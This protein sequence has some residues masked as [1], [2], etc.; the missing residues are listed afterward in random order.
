MNILP[1]V[2]DQVYDVD[3]R[4][5][6]FAEIE[7]LGF[8]V[9]C[10]SCCAIQ[11]EDLVG[12][13]KDTYMGFASDARSKG[14]IA[15]VSI[16]TSLSAGDRVG[17]TEA[18]RDESDNPR[19][20]TRGFH[21]SYA[22]DSWKAYLIELIDL[23]VSV[24]GYQCVIL[25]GCTY[26]SDLPG[27]SGP[28]AAKFASE[29]PDIT[30]PSQ[31]TETSECLKAQQFRDKTVLG[32]F[33]DLA[34]HAKSIE[35][36]YVGIIPPFFIPTVGASGGHSSGSYLLAA[37]PNVD[38]LVSRLVPED[39]QSEVFQT[40]NGIQR[41]PKLC[42]AEILAHSSR[43][44]SIAFGDRITDCDG[45]AEISDEFARDCALAALAAAPCGLVGQQ[46]F[47][48][49]IGFVGRMG[50][51]K[52]S[53]AFVF[54]Q[55]S[56]QNLTSE[57]VFEHYWTLARYMAYEIHMPM[58]TFQADTLEQD[59]AAHP[60]V[61]VLV[62]E[63][64]FPLSVDQMR[65]IR[66]WWNGSL[67]R[68]VVAFGLG[69]GCSVDS[70]GISPSA[71][72]YPGV[73]EL[74]GLKHEDELVLRFNNPIALSDTSRVR[75]SA[76]FGEELPKTIKA[77]ANVRRVFGSRANV[78]YDLEYGDVRVPVVAEWRDRS[79]LAVFCGFGLSSE[80]T[81][82]AAE[83]IQYVLKEV[84]AKPVMVESCSEG[85]LWNATQN[86]YVI[87]CNISDEKG[88]ATVKPG[89]ANLWDCSKQ[90]MVPDGD[91][92]LNLEPHSAVLLRAVGKRA[93]LLDVLGSSCL[94]TLID[95]AGR[96]E[97][98]LL[99]GQS[100]TFVL[101]SSPRDIYVDGKPRATSQKVEDGVYY[102]T[103][104]QC[105]P[106]KHKISLRW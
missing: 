87:L 58:L 26:I 13:Y 98:E 66:G 105:P 33:S 30:Y 100:T 86:D 90:K 1:V 10:I 46:S 35:A 101:K 93:K 88:A 31:R 50:Q 103:L 36:E 83:A 62:L 22:S 104:Q 65:V 5:S 11:F 41:S 15:S 68:A 8:D 52:A 57:S 3:A 97:I 21:A 39:I 84:D 73:L 102:V 74:I 71:Q 2:P 89:R 53:V 61:Q 64:H 37:V 7:K 91:L 27:P 4:S 54:S 29:Y 69:E 106:G 55:S 9:A 47:M 6:Y 77:V 44:P 16:H 19:T 80:T 82:I 24:Y 18:Q 25:D 72:C 43:K 63:E 76:F 48:E 81:E 17:I 12:K 51:P 94:Y 60:E 59:L 45:K 38:F 79:T 92:N 14:C 32:F 56:M 85:V 99:A 20:E 70:P 96:A 67:K 75:R 28:F 95:G 78:L 42:Y 40:G 34:A 23:F 49:E